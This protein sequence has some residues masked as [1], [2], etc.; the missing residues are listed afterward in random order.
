MD[1]VTPYR[2]PTRS[3][4]LRETGRTSQAASRR[5][6]ETTAAEPSAK[7]ERRPTL[8]GGS[9]ESVLRSP[10][11]T[12]LSEGL[13]AAGLSRR[14][15][16]AAPVPTT[17]GDVFRD[18]ERRAATPS[19]EL[20]TRA[21]TSMASY[22]SDHRH[23]DD[24]GEQQP[25]STRRQHRTTQS[26]ATE[27]DFARTG[28]VE[29]ARDAPR[30]S[31]VSKHS[32][33]PSYP[34][35]RQSQA[36]VTST[37]HLRLMLETLQAFEANVSKLPSGVTNS[38]MSSATDLLKHAQHLVHITERINALMR[39]GTN[40]ALEEQ[41]QAEVDVSE[42]VAAEEMLDVWRLVGGEY[43]EGLRASDDLVR[44][45]TSFLIDVGSTLRKLSPNCGETD[46]STPS[47]HVRS[48]S[49]EEEGVRVQARSGAGSELNGRKSIDLESMSRKSQNREEALRKLGGGGTGRESSLGRAARASP[50]LAAL[51]DRERT[52]HN[53]PSPAST[54]TKPLPS[55]SAQTPGNPVRRLFTPSQQR[56]R[57]LETKLEVGT[58]RSSAL[59]PSQHTIQDPEV[60]PSPTP[61]SRTMDRSRAL[62]AIP[63]S[64]SPPSLS[65]MTPVSKAVSNST[66]SSSAASASVQRSV[67]TRESDRQRR[68]PSIASIATIRGSQ[69][70]PNL[71]TPS[72][73]VTSVTPTTVSH[74][75]DVPELLRTE[76]MH[77][78]KSGITFSRPSTSAL[79]GI[80]HQARDGHRKSSYSIGDGPQ[81][82]HED[83]PAPSRGAFASRTFSKARAPP[84]LQTNSRPRLSPRVSST[85]YVSN[86]VR[87]PETPFSKGST[88]H[89]ADRHAASTMLPHRTN[90]MAR[91][92][93]RAVSD[94]FPQ[95]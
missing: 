90:S 34:S 87:N 52:F 36:A 68:K 77:S 81:A 84:E 85:E 33:L 28:E 47:P 71:T 12:L 92:R 1:L 40:K 54:S 23:R 60:E 66:S 61:A 63:I 48:L 11:R 31:A 26:M 86:T 73:A 9:A 43:R 64:D 25:T 17:S 49:L 3:S 82:E 65:R 83:S 22:R 53:T 21:A 91:E 55:L 18:R 7:R 95:E 44:A 37:E 27:R 93:R 24:D 57:E 51:R 74:S 10:G 69:A 45:L 39:N 35:K 15:E 50:A 6:D 20:A 80:Q 62:P 32:D 58:R 70:P 88:S 46:H 67:S 16:V 19:R 13:R 89:A 42:S 2:A 75:H 14:E 5:L 78:G 8:R 4:T 94:I 59:H 79:S 56:E 29:H 38:K 41:I 30:R 76:S 72:T